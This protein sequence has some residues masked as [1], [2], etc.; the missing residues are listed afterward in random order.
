MADQDSPTNQA[1]TPGTPFFNLT[2]ALQA[3]YASRGMWA[4]RQPCSTLAGM[5]GPRVPWDSNAGIAFYVNAEQLATLAQDIAANGRRGLSGQQVGQ[6]LRRLREAATRAGTQP[7]WATPNR[8]P[9]NALAPQPFEPL[10]CPPAGSK[11]RFAFEHHLMQCLREVITLSQG[12][13]Y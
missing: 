13:T 7:L 8:Q 5:L 11:A 12:S 9:P 10:I 2:P 4:N 6:A 1:P 3:F